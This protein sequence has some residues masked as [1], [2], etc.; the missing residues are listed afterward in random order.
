[1]KDNKIISMFLP[2]FMG[3]TSLIILFGLISTGVLNFILT[4]NSGSIAG[5]SVSSSLILLVTLLII[6]F[7]LN[8]FLFSNRGYDKANFYK[9]FQGK[10]IFM[11]FSYLP[12]LFLLLFMYIN[13]LLVLMIGAIY[14]LIGSLVLSLL[15]N[16]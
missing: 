16:E 1:M 3:V 12:V 8:L 7:G 11:F 10:I 5:I 2:I 9:K 15:K 13:F 14:I 6:N 4:E